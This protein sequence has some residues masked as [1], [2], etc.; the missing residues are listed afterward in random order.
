MDE[1][2]SQNFGNSNNTSSSKKSKPIENFDPQAANH[3]KDTFQQIEELKK[4]HSKSVLHKHFNELVSDDERRRLKRM[5]KL[6]EKLKK[7]K[8]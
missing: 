3:Y 8:M 1:L 5:Q 6:N 7:I 4:M 2:Y